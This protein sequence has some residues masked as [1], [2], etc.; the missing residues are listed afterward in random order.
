MKNITLEE[1]NIPY[2]TKMGKI[3][4]T[5]YQDVFKRSMEIYTQIKGKSKRK[6]YIRSAYFGKQKVFFD[7][8]WIHLWHKGGYKERVRRLKYF[9]AAI[10]VLKHSKNKPTSK[11]NPNKLSETL[12]RFTGP[13][14]DNELFYV[15][16]KE[17]VPS[18]KKFFMS[19]FPAK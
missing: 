12:H 10:E 2:K 7:Y 6:P 11:F 8:F 9:E 19:C 3:P 14:E 5:S 17:H 15:Q 1:E 18:G 16:V 13:T 4:G